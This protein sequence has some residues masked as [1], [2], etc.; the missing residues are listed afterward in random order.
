MRIHSAKA[1]QIAAEMV[2]ALTTDGAIEVDAPGEVELDIASVISQYVKDEQEVSDRARDMLAQR[3]LPPT[4]L[5]KLRRL[6]AD[7]K[8]IKLGD[9]AIDYL[10]DQL[11]EMLM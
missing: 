5:G 6:F 10:L 7:Q 8:K 1:P 4:D 11:V 3:N 2:P 9:E